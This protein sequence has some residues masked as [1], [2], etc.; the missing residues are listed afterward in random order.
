[1][2]DK[3]MREKAAPLLAT[4]RAIDYEL[5]ELYE[6][7][8]KLLRADND[9]AVIDFSDLGADTRSLDNVIFRKVLGQ[10][11]HTATH[12]WGIF[13]DLVDEFWPRINLLV[14]YPTEQM[15][16]WGNEL[17][18]HQVET[19]PKITFH[20]PYRNQSYWTLLF[21]GQEVDKPHLQS[22]H[23]IWGN[24]PSNEL[25]KGKVLVPY[26]PAVPTSYGGLHRYM[27]M[28]CS[29]NIP[30]TINEDD[31]NRGDAEN[32]VKSTT[33][34]IDFNWIPPHTTTQH[35]NQFIL[36]EFLSVYPM[37]KPKGLCFFHTKWHPSVPGSHDILDC[38][39]KMTP[40]QLKQQINVA[41]QHSPGSAL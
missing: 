32:S 18:P 21:I 12:I 27:W 28:L 13:P 34:I 19:M 22:I 37:I 26:I 11:I 41:K 20:C 6:T 30:G 24:I 9:E 25:V 1:M 8:N 29:Q 23:G 7:P 14:E 10:K 33:Q 3:E 31:L 36:R 4:D 16:Y 15:A 2:S 40:E 17:E 38:Y 5:P 39:P 35:R